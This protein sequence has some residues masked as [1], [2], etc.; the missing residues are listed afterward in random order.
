MLNRHALITVLTLA[1][2][3]LALTAC[4]GAGA[5]PSLVPQAQ[6]APSFISNDASMPSLSGQWAGTAHDSLW[7]RLYGSGRVYAQLVQYHNAVGG[8]F[9]FDYGSSTL[10]GASV[11]LSKGTT[12]TGLGL[13][14]NLSLVT[15]TVSETA[16]FSNHSLNGSY[17]AL[18]GCSGDN[19]TYT[20]KEYCR[21]A[22][23]SCGAGAPPNLA[24]HAE[25][26]PSLI[27]NDASIPNLSGEY[28][29]T[30][31]DSVFGSG[32]AYAE[33][34]QYHN[35]VGGSTLFE[36]AG[37]TVFI[38][39]NVFLLKGTTLTGTAEGAT[40]SGVPCTMS[41]TAMYSDHRLTGSYKAVNGCSGES[42]T[43]TVKESC[44][45]VT[46]SIAEPRF[47]L[48]DCSPY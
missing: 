1:L 6:V 32:K 28:A 23:K 36:Y 48:K 20:M 44:R 26:A 8:N 25:V 17:K 39:P 16:L 33:L 15:C 19:G 40:L 18:R 24:P 4:G 46:E 27:S 12:L 30:V 43:F 35:A 41:E 2:A 42:G 7:D 29:G 34:L 38:D 5:P 10:G 13:T 21:Y 3:G 9:S 31:N 37:S 22:T 47:A 14:A 11:F 45:F